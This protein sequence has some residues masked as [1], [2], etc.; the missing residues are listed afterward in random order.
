M[1]LQ[2]FDLLWCSEPTETCLHEGAELEL[3]EAALNIWGPRAERFVTEMGRCPACGQWYGPLPLLYDIMEGFGW[4]AS[5]IEGFGLEGK[6]APAGVVL[7]EATI[8]WATFGQQIGRMQEAGGPP[9]SEEEVR[10]LS[11]APTTWEIGQAPASWVEGDSEEVE[12]GYVA[13]ACG[14]ALA[15]GTEIKVR[16]PLDGEELSGLLRR[17]TASP[18]PPAEPGRPKRVRARDEATAEALRPSLSS[19]GIE[20]EVGETPLADEALEEITAM[21]LGH[22]APPVFQGKSDE[23]TKAFLET[24]TRFYQREPWTRTEGDRFLGI[25]I[26]EGDWFFANV[27][28]QMEESPGLSLFDDWLTVCRFVHN[29]RSPFFA[30]VEDLGLTG[31]SGFLQELAGVGQVGPFEAAGALEGLSL[32]DREELHPADARR[33]DELS[34]GPPVRG[35]SFRGQ[36]P[37]PHRFDAGEGLVAP[38]FSLDTYRLVIEALLI[39]LERRRATPVTS[40]KTTLDMGGTP[41]SL[42]YP[43]DGTERP[44]EDPPG[45]RLFLRGHDEDIHSPSRIPEGKLIEIEAPATALFKDVAKA[46]GQFH[47][48]IYEASLQDWKSCLWDDRASRRNPSPR[49]ADLADLEEP[50]ELE[51][52]IGGGA[53]GLAI[54][55]ALDQPPEEIQLQWTFR[56]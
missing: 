27:M 28:G 5:D 14:P 2:S 45:Y 23:E 34:I 47:D 50:P 17:A 10:A 22:S 44:Y 53:F 38:R 3:R 30:L 49:I 20:V 37:V 33:L 11:Q 52:E 46:L 48:E 55:Q 26:G 24:A 39:A 18:L 35:R 25:Q 40:I 41:V 29:Q 56:E 54:G 36:Y 9:P 51:I 19:L 32:S 6:E 16:A 42:R 12:L 1:E 4:D 8:P 13:V 43:S 21:L 7:G 15:R 31:E